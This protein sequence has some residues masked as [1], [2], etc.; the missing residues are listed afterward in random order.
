MKGKRL[1]Q[2]KTWKNFQMKAKKGDEDGRYRMRVA[3]EGN[4]RKSPGR[5]TGGQK[6]GD[7][8]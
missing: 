1:V 4:H 6:K 7:T 3:S 5:K 8:T 2:R